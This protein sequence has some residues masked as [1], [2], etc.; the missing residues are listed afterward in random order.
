M[1]LVSSFHG[2]E[3]LSAQILTHAY[4]YLSGH[5]I[6]F[7]PLVNPSGY[8]HSIRTEYPSM[9]DP[10]RD[11]PYDTDPNTC[12]RGAASRIMDRIYRHWKIDLT[13]TIHQGGD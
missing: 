8:A 12:M 7:M 10:N 13:I 4:P 1:L 11:F 6:L 9:I 3:T 2:N 5:H